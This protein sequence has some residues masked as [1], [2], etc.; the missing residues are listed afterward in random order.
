M[1][2]TLT[3]LPLVKEGLLVQTLQGRERDPGLE[4]VSA[5][6]SGLEGRVVAWDLSTVTAVPSFGEKEAQTSPTGPRAALHWLP[7]S[8]EPPGVQAGGEAAW[9]SC[10]PQG[11]STS[12]DLYLDLSPQ[13]DLSEVKMSAGDKGWG[14]LSEE[15]GF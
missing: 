6:W 9:E 14:S 1:A 4:E 12:C 10:S 2:V 3:S 11:S 7:G 15:K 8:A 13:S 5:Q